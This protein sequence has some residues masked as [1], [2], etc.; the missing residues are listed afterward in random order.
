VRHPETVFLGRRQLIIG[1]RHGP[2]HLPPFDR[3]ID[4]ALLHVI[5]LE[6]LSEPSSQG[7]GA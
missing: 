6:P 4:V 2:S 3:M 7:N 1:V 5:R